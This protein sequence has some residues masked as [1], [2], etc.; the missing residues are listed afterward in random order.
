M[1]KRRRPPPD[2]IAVIQAA[3]NAVRLMIQLER[4]P[5]TKHNRHLTAARVELAA[6]LHDAQHPVTFPRECPGHGRGGLLPPCCDHAG[7][8]YDFLAD[9]PQPNRCPSHCSCHD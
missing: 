6:A 2:I 3:Q 9:P 5:R 7:E 1:P 8:P 4:D